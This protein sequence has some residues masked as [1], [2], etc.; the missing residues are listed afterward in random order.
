VDSEEIDRHLTDLS[1]SNPVTESGA[2]EAAERREDLLSKSGLLL[3][4]PRGRAGFYHLSFQEFLAAGR[5]RSAREAPKA[6]LERHAA[7]P[8]WHRTLRFLFCAIADKESPDAAM[9]AFQGLL[10]HLTPAE[11][12]RNPQ[13]ALLL[14]D[15]MEVAHGRGWSITGFA[16]PLR[17]ACGHALARLNPPE[18]TRLWRTLGRLGLDDRAGVG[19][20]EGVPDIDW[21]EVPAGPFLYGEERKPRQLRAFRIARHPITNAQFQ[22]FLDDGGYQT[23]EWWDGLAERLEP[24]SGRWTDPN[25]PRETVPWYEA[26]AYARWLDAR[27]RQ[28]NRLPAGWTI[29]LPTEEEWEKAARGGDGREFPWGQFASGLANVN[30]TWGDAGPYYFGQTSPVGVYPAGA[31]PCGMLDASGNVW[32][33]CL[34]ESQHPDLTGTAGNA[35]RVARG[36]SWDNARGSARCAYRRGRAPGC[37]DDILGF[38]LLS[39]SPIL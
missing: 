17:R 13:P 38:R 34:N 15:C 33:W 21:V 27:L 29:R 14:A 18:R 5:L 4:R 31:S 2:V 6:V 8:A 28:R 26:V 23:E 32:E 30:E 20:K 7:T 35:R 39:V 9:D 12:D 22:S 24:R 3:P 11:L 16:E 25:H 10:R 36:G 19:L 37:R 1:K